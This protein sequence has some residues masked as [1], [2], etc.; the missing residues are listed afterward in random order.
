MKSLSILALPV[1][2]NVTDWVPK[3]LL[4][5]KIHTTPY[6]HKCCCLQPPSPLP[7]KQGELGR[8]GCCWFSAPVCL[9]C[10]RGQKWWHCHPCQGSWPFQGRTAGN[11]DTGDISSLHSQWQA[12]DPPQQ[13]GNALSMLRERSRKPLCL[14]DSSP[15]QPEPSIF[16]CTP[17]QQSYLYT[18]GGCKEL[19]Y[20]LFSFNDLCHSPLGIPICTMQILLSPWQYCE[21]HEQQYLVHQLFESSSAPELSPPLHSPCPPHLL[22]VSLPSLQ[23]FLAAR[24]APGSS[25]PH[26]QLVLPDP[27]LC[28]MIA[29]LHT[30]SSSGHTRR[31]AAKQ[32]LPASVI[33]AAALTGWDERYMS[34]YLRQ[35]GEKR[36][37]YIVINLYDVRAI[38]RGN[39]RI[40]RN[41]FFQTT[42]L[43]KVRESGFM[44]RIKNV[45]IFAITSIN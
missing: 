35:D 37:Q 16:L 5:K 30:G 3:N 39:V 25:T 26:L 42:A 8:V 4:M 22:T 36:G 19:I 7:H 21:C 2:Q 33:Q 11:C 13:W 40:D 12:L 15:T 31:G 44:L 20:Y 43:Q 23:P 34:V 10:P 24:L 28:S 18:C 29:S 41:S 17:H 9:G 6:K 1:W 38:G 27:R 32:T 14:V 45:C